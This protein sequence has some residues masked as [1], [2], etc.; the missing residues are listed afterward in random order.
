MDITTVVA[1]A[2][3]ALCCVVVW[4][5]HHR[6]TAR[7]NTRKSTQKREGLSLRNHA[8]FALACYW[9]HYY[10]GWSLALFRDDSGAIRH[11]ACEVPDGTFFDSGGYCS[12]DQIVQRL[13]LGVTAENCDETDVQSL[14][15]SNGAV[16]EAAEELRNRVERSA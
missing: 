8:A 6:K 4:R 15:H 12:G 11:V 13:R 3:G 5:T 9:S 10:E 14:L 1:G 16:L 7:R 2:F